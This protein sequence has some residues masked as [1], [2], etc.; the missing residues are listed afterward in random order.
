MANKF[1]CLVCNVN[2][3]VTD[4]DIR[5]DRQGQVRCPV[6]DGVLE[7]TKKKRKKPTGVYIHLGAEL[8][9]KVADKAGRQHKTAGVYCREVLEREALR[10]HQ[11]RR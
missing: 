1:Y 6:C 7:F 5:V 4:G 11:K 3:S 9:A 10:S 2:Y 8:Y